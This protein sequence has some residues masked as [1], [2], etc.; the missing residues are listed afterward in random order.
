MFSQWSVLRNRKVPLVG[1][2]ALREGNFLIL[3]RVVMELIRGI[4]KR[5][6]QPYAVRHIS[7]ES[8]S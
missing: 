4:A 7:E 2:P 1:L 6:T 8:I 5:G 3:T